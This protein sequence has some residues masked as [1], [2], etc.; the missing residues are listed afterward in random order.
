MRTASLLLI[1]GLCGHGPAW[2]QSWI[3]QISVMIQEEKATIVISDYFADIS[4]FDQVNQLRNEEF[5][6]ES[7]PFDTTGQY[8]AAKNRLNQ[9]LQFT[10]QH[11]SIIPVRNNN[12]DL[13]SRITLHFEDHGRMEVSPDHLNR[14]LTDALLAKNIKNCLQAWAADESKN[15]V[16]RANGSGAVAAMKVLISFEKQHNVVKIKWKYVSSYTLLTPPENMASS[17]K[18]MPVRGARKR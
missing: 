18:A 14:S 12:S 9:F 4:L 3:D 7:L 10:T 13:T 1:I 17:E 2:A 8:T 6:L 16:L 15:K 11:I 5:R